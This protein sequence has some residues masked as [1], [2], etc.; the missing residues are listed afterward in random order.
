MSIGRQEFYIRDEGFTKTHSL[1]NRKKGIC[2]QHDQKPELDQE[3]GIQ[4]HH[5]GAYCTK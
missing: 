4:N 3:K 5:T 2:D 1:Q